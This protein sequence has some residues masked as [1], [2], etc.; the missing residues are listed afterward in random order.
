VELTDELLAGGHRLESETDTEVLAHV[1]E[2]SLASDPASGLVGAVRSAIGR[3]RGTFS[4][5]VVHADDP[6]LIVA[7]RRVSRC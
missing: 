5:A 7:S 1:I 2:D 4:V 3:I 6:H